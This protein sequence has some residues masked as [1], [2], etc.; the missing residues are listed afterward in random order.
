MFHAAQLDMEMVM[1]FSLYHQPGPQKLK[2]IN[3]MWT[4]AHWRKSRA[5]LPSADAQAVA[6]AHPARGSCTSASRDFTGLLR[7]H[8][9]RE[10][11]SR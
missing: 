7:Q 3:W 8:S 6:A 2:K 1:K 9:G 10:Q 11:I 4:P 5:F